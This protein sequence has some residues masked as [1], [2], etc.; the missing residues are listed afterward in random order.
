MKIINPIYSKAD[1]SSVDCDIEHPEH[2]W[3]TTTVLLDGSDTAEH[4][5]ELVIYFTAS[6]SVIAD[7]VA[8]I[9]DSIVAAKQARDSG[10]YLPIEVGGRIFD[11]HE[12]AQR[13]IEGAIR[14]FSLLDSMLR[15]D[16]TLDWTLAD[17]SDIPV[18]LSDLV[19]VEDA[20][21]LR[22]ALLH[23]QYTALKKAS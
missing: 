14:K 2:G 19:A 17:N 6:P 15:S 18:T 13:N 3:I 4:N 16:G 22:Y 5:K 10:Q 20:I 21:A 7:Y 23:A 9:V 1:N 11:A 8:P 12:A